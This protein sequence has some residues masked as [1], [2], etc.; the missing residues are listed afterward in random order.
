MSVMLGL[1]SSKGTD[2]IQTDNK[3]ELHME[4]GLKAKWAW[5]PLDTL[6]LRFPRWYRT[7]PDFIWRRQIYI[8]SETCVCKRTHIHMHTLSSSGSI[9][10]AEQRGEKTGEDRRERKDQ[11]EQ[12]NEDGFKFRSHFTSFPTHCTKHV[13]FRI[14][15]S[16]TLTQ[17]CLIR[18]SVAG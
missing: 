7:K 10:K 1:Q 12:R 2:A 8:M 15:V 18:P 16:L 11:R 13:V 6:S 3:A 4:M 9:D 5:A 17:I 14:P